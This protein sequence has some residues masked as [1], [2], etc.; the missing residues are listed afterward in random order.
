MYWIFKISE[1]VILVGRSCNVQY[2]NKCQYYIINWWILIVW[3]DKNDIYGC[4]GILQKKLILLYNNIFLSYYVIVMILSELL[5]WFY[6]NL[7]RIYKKWLIT[8]ECNKYFIWRYPLV[9][10]VI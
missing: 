7:F 10:K 4:M 9:K 2:Y 5:K 1:N 6:N 3:I 8:N